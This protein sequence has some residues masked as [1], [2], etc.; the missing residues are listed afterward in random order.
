MDVWDVYI[1]ILFAIAAVCFVLSKVKKGKAKRLTAEA[2]SAWDA[3]NDSAAISLF[4]EAL[5]KA[6]EEPALEEKIIASL[7]ALYSKVGIHWD[8]SGYEALVEQFKWLSKKSSNKAMRE[9]GEVQ[10]LKKE[11]LDRMPDLNAAA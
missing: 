1:G 5:W 7:N 10:G 11:V 9:L 2:E 3:G 6:N 8:F 4:K